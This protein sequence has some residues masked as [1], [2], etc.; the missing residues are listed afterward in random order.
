MS[1]KYKTLNIFSYITLVV[2]I[3]LLAIAG[4]LLFWPVDP[5]IFN[6]S[7][8]ME[9]EVYYVG[10]PLNIY[11]DFCKTGDYPADVNYILIDGV[12]YSL[13]QFSNNRPA[14]C[15]KGIVSSGLMVP[16]VP[17]GTYKL[18]W[19]GTFYVNPLKIVVEEFTTPPF[20]IING[21]D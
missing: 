15:F 3:A 6:E 16:N 8:H 18:M 21:K 13:P 17:S 14:G 7:P 12:S 9:K 5:L 1:V 2:T 4:I 11:M 20:K 10:A 19:R